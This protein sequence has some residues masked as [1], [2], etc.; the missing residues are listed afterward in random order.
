MKQVELRLL[1]QKAINQQTDIYE[2]LKDDLNPQTRAIAERTKGQKDALS[3]VLSAI[4]GNPVYLR[5]LG[6]RT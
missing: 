3:D 4:D 5:M 6:D 1:L 2:Q